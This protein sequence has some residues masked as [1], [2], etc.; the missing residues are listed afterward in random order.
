VFASLADCAGSGRGARG[1]R[2]VGA[3]SVAARACPP[4]PIRRRDLAPRRH[5]QSQ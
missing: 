3:P 5:A 1:P 2:R 4:S